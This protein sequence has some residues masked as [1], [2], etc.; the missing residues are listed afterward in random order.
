MK[1]PA[2]KQSSPGRLLQLQVYS[3][4]SF[5]DKLTFTKHLTTMIKAGIPLSEALSALADQT[6][7]GK[8]R[9]SLVKIT[10]DVENGSPLTKAFAKHPHLFDQFYLSL[11]EVGEE[12]GTLETS[13][14]FLSKQL[15]KDYSLRKKIQSA[16]LYPAIIIT[17][18]LIMGTYIS[19]FVLPKLVDFFK[20]FGADLPLST[21]ILLFFA[22]TMKNFGTL[23]LA[24]LVALIVI[25][26]SLIR[27]PAIT[28][29]WHRFL[30]RLPLFGKLFAFGQLARFSR[31]LGVLLQSAV[32]ITRALE[33]TALTLSNLK[34]R[35]DL[36]AVSSDLAEGQ[37][38]SHAL[39]K[40]QYQE[41]PPLVSTMIAVGE[42]TGRLD[43]TLLYLGEF[44]DD[45]IESLSKDLSTVLEPLLLI[46]IG[47]ILGFVALAI[48]TPIY[49]LSGAIGK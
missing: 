30:L 41:F 38:I 47:L 21:Q 48:I 18:T 31:N 7:S 15:A 39:I 11:V 14:D 5:L 26:L 19:V 28:L 46:V 17:A 40:G 2:R 22:T 43:E 33:V 36:L 45:E 6:T 9:R 20:A 10:R 3:R 27:L 25:F 4:V 13:L 1:H 49:E 35:Q 16:L 34:F 29:L 24:A 42:K 8:F 37:T 12:S 23:I 32:P 44:Y